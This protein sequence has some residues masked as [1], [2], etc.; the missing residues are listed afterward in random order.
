MSSAAADRQVDAA[1][2]P[3]S[4]RPRMHRSWVALLVA[5]VF[6]SYI[7]FVTPIAVSLAFRVNH[8]APN[9]SEYLGIILSAGAVASLLSGPFAGQF[10]DRTRSRI[11]R[12]RPWIIGGMAVGIVGLFVIGIAPNVLVVGV[13]WVIS[14]LGWSQV[15]NNITTLLADKLPEAQRGR[16]SGLTGAVTGVAPVAGAVIGSGFAAQPVLL[17]MIPAA[18]SVVLI[19]PFLVVAQD[20]DSRQMPPAPPMTFKSVIAGFVFNPRKYPDFAKNW[21]GRVLYFFGLTLST[22]YTAYFFGQR[23]GIPVS[24]TGRAVATVGGIGVAGALAGALLTGFFSDRIHRRKPFILGSAVLF[25]AGCVLMLLAAGLPLL[26]AGTALTN[27][28]IGS[29]GAVDQ[30][31]MLDVLPEKATEAG[32][33]V[34]IFAYATSLPQAAAPAAAAGLLFITGGR[35]YI[36]LYAAAGVLT[37][38]GAII[39]Q[40]IEAVQ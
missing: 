37:I 28:A 25:A 4:D 31:L 17:L 38:A 39:I 15:L 23:L 6:G 14:Q 11:G 32:R 21:T 35:N 16:V 26:I 20:R 3:A 19:V 12:R 22:T 5:A 18:I 10:S 27:L 33:Y 29:F 40:R 36:P 2:I 7:A 9:N 8:L 1:A 13:G 24:H 30:A 34:N